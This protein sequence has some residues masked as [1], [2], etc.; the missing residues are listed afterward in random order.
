[1]SIHKYFK[2]ID[3]NLEPTK[4]VAVGAAVDA[5]R[6]DDV[7]NQDGAAS[8]DLTEEKEASKTDASSSQKKRPKLRNDE[9]IA[10]GFFR[11]VHE[12]S[13]PF[14]RGKCFFCNATYSNE[15][16]VPSKLAR[17]LK[18]KHPEHQN[19]SKQFF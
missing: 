13:N 14:P 6:K 9:H 1:M 17:H 18:T 3:D 10:F 8:Q 19:K 4:P 11:T 5:T 15:N 12:A 2:K 16:V 7:S